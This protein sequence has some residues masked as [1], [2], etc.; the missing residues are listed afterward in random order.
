MKKTFGRLAVFAVLAVLVLSLQGA[1][2]A[3]PSGTATASST[4]VRL[5]AG[6]RTISLGTDVAESARGKATSALARLI[7]GR[8]NGVSIGAGEKSAQTRS[9]SGRIDIAK[10]DPQAIDGLLAL[11]GVQGS[12]E[13]KIT[14]VNVQSLVSLELGDS[15]VLGRL[16]ALGGGSSSSK[17]LVNGTKA[18]S[19]RTIGIDSIEVLAIGDFLAALGVDPFALACD[20][21]ETVGAKVGKDASQACEQLQAAKTSIDGAKSAL[22]AARADLSAQ[23]TALEQQVAG[24]T[25]SEV[26]QDRGTVAATNCDITD[27]ACQVTAL[28][29]SFSSMGSKYGVPLTG[30]SFFNAKSSLLTAMD[31]ILD[32]FDRIDQ[33]A[34]EIDV[35]DGDIAT[36]SSGTCAGVTAAL[37]D[38]SA[39]V[40]SLKTALDPATAA[41]ASACGS[42][43]ATVQGLLDTPLLQLDG[44][45]MSISAVATPSGPEAKVTG[46]IGN[47]KVGLLEPVGVDL[48]VVSGK[49]AEVQTLVEAKL[50]EIAQAI[51]IDLP[52]PEFEL[53]VKDTDEGRRA[54]G[55]YFA[56]GS[57]T[58]V[59]V[60]MPAAELTV[61]AALPLG[62]LGDSPIG[63]A[64]AAVQ[65][66]PALT[67]D[68]GVFRA[69]STFKTAGT[70][71]GS[72]SPSGA[73]AGGGNLPRT[74]V[75]GGPLLL[76]AGIL[77]LSAAALVRRFLTQS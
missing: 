67:L 54:D 2:A 23:K 12:V 63:I 56:E 24:K 41:V 6:D 72:S 22:A 13:A 8:V 42:L 36:A 60:H 39:A 3:A 37:S 10:A 19:T 29:G 26:E 61:P 1:Q 4:L 43:E 27:L 68:L 38:A 30:L 69:A 16:A 7:A 73:P 66:S 57:V 15:A 21:V 55:T 14:S 70:S 31:A 28:A 9:D 48:S 17:T 49:V 18:S 5:V 35:L 75:A 25:R 40:P 59:R 51:G 47:L 74:G 52:T 34:S 20:A 76:I 77:S 44:V 33:K 11:G 64:A 32:A 50:D 46:T 58:A 45:T 53:L 65:A 62:V 71:S